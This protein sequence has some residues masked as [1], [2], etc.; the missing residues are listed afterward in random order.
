MAIKKYRGGKYSNQ[1]YGDG[2][3]GRNEAGNPN[4]MGNA[5]SPDKREF[6]GSNSQRYTFS[7]DALGVHTIVASSYEDAL[8]IAE[9][10]GFHE[11]DYKKRHRKRRS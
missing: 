7:N 8:R 9:S 11:K 6:K 1:L 3:F 2:H 5:E 10:L 4:Y